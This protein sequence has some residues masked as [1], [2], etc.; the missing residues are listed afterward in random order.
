MY[1]DN[2]YARGGNMLLKRQVTVD[3]DQCGKACS[4]NFCQQLTVAQ[5]YPA[6]IPSRG[7]GNPR[8][9]IAKATRY[10]LVEQDLH[11]AMARASSSSLASSR[12][13]TA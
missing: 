9:R 8:E 12:T 11:Y 6:L 13:A 5:T 7:Y 10:A 2:G 4:T 3:G 1:D